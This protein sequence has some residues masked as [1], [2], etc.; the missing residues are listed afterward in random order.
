MISLFRN[1]ERKRQLETVPTTAPDATGEKSWLEITD[2]PNVAYKRSDR[3]HRITVE[4]T[5]GSAPEAAIF[6]MGSCFAREIRIALRARKMDVFPRYFDID[7]DPRCQKLS[8]LPEYDDVNHYDTYT[9][10]Q[11]FEQ[12]F[13]GTHY[14]EG[15]FIRHSHRLRNEFQAGGRTTWQDPY[16][17][18]VY[19]A[20]SGSI[21]DL[22][23]ALDRTIAEGIH[24]A[25][26][27]I[28]T[29]GLIETWRLKSNGLHICTRPNTNS[30]D[31]QDRVEFHLTGFQENYENLRY[32]CDMIRHHYPD[33][34]IVLTVSPVGLKRT[35]RDIDVVVA[36]T[37]SKSLLRTVAGQI[38]REFDNVSYWPSYELSLRHDVYEQDGR[39]IKKEVV[40]HIID[41]FQE[42]QFANAGQN[43]VPIHRN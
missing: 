37:E 27:Y 13:A 1:R 24:T 36:N 6:A 4:R 29:L 3:G 14:G 35:F 12:A 30:D 17:K 7:F 22:S 42:A 40:D 26:T 5:A 16:R 39:H 9:I 20:D 15:D 43:V 33:R 25:K 31:V 11:E 28:I 41:V 38:E 23:S 18:H 34:R 8:K 19:A 21:L 10:R 32:V 2:A